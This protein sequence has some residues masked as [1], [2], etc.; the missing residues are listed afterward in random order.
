MTTHLTIYFQVYTIKQ[1]KHG[2]CPNDD[3]RYLLSD[4]CDGRPNPHT[5]AYG[6]RD[7]AGKEQEVAD[8]PDP[9]AEL[10]IWHREERFTL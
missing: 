9:G 10:I 5:H 6:H 1:E 3:K 8:Q 2:L 4:L 7:L